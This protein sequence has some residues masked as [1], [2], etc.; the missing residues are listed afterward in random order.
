M[1]RKNHIESRQK[2]GKALCGAN[3]PRG[4][5]PWDNVESCDKCLDRKDAADR[6]YY[7]SQRQVKSSVSN[8]ELGVQRSKEAMRRKAQSMVGLDIFD[9]V[10]QIAVGFQY[11]PKVKRKQLIKDKAREAVKLAV[12]YWK[13]Q[14]ARLPIKDLAAFDENFNKR[15]FESAV[16]EVASRWE[17]EAEMDD[18]TF[19]EQNRP[20]R[21]SLEAVVLKLASTNREVRRVLIAAL[22]VGL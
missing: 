14:N 22:R 20:R 2:P 18:D 21:A 9:F 11:D 15:S 5:D 8:G 17:H 12:I 13:K 16:R 19:E 1:A 4:S 6:A 3:I 7:E 10:T